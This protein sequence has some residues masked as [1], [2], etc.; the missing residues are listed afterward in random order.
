[1]I[2]QILHGTEGEMRLKIHGLW[3][4]VEPN[5]AYNI[6]RQPKQTILF[7][8]TKSRK[9]FLIALRVKFL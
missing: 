8:L 3:F 7:A 4:T 6:T 2:A 9:R 5:T 1:M